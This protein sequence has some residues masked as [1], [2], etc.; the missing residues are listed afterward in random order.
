MDYMEQNADKFTVLDRLIELGEA[1]PATMSIEEFL[2][3]PIPSA[4]SGG[5]SEALADL[6]NDAR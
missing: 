6:R 3:T 2:E 4:T 1:T 5:V